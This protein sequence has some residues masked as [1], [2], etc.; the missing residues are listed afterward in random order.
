MSDNPRIAP[1]VASIILPF[2]KL[3]AKLNASDG[4]HVPAPAQEHTD[5][6]EP[7]PSNSNFEMHLLYSGTSF[8]FLK[9]CMALLSRLLE[10]LL[11]QETAATCSNLD[12]EILRI[13]KCN[14]A[15]DDELTEYFSRNDSQDGFVFD[16]LLDDSKHII[17]RLLRLS[18]IIRNPTPHNHFLS[19]Q[20]A[21]VIQY[22]EPFDI[23]HV[24][25]KFPKLAREV[26][27][28]LGKSLS[29]RRQYFRYREEHFHRLADGLPGSETELL[30]PHEQ[31]TTIAS[32]I[33]NHL[34]TVKTCD[35]SFDDIDG[36]SELSATS[37]AASEVNSDQLRVPPMPS[38]YANGP[39][40]CPFCH[41]IIQIASKLYGRRKDWSKHMYLEHWTLWK[42]PSGCHKYMHSAEEFQQHLS[43][44]HKDELSE[45][46]TGSLARLCSVS[47]PAQA[48]G[49]CIFCDHHLTSDK[50]Y[51]SHVA[52]H[53]EQLSLFALPSVDYDQDEDDDGFEEG[54]KQVDD[55]KTD[56]TNCEPEQEVSEDNN[57]DSG[58]SSVHDHVNDDHIDHG[59][60]KLY[61]G[62]HVKWYCIRPFTLSFGRI[63]SRLSAPEM[64]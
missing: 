7:G 57:S 4:P 49:P 12:P 64:F 36:R 6:E 38:G 61:E 44:V 16:E 3:I 60:H 10:V 5:L 59:V 1:L 51:I 62:R 37:Y 28:R 2:D 13:H 46:H 33:P 11:S 41:S 24:H 18:L 20:A 15:F 55:D 45:H 21:E 31:A 23:H 40:K 42:C 32:P 9:N 8:P 52:L 19:R 53:L 29:V 48:R 50:L 26:A 58:D 14:E 34:E 27:E 35:I 63:L 25:E 17:D 43:S 56:D 30:D 39:I 47:D 22:S 54:D